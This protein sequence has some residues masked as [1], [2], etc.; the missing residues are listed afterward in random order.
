MFARRDIVA[1]LLLFN[2]FCVLMKNVN[3]ETDGCFCKLKGE[4]DDCGCTV[5]SVD[6]FNNFKIYPRIN[7]L[8]QKDFFK[9]FKVNLKRTCPFWPDDSRCSLRDCHVEQCTEVPANIKGFSEKKRKHEKNKYSEE[10][11]KEEKDEDCD[12]ELGN[13]DKTISV[14]GQKQFKT[15]Q[16]HDDAQNYFCELDDEKSTDSD[17][18]DLLRNP[19]RY[20]GYVGNSPQRIWHSIYEENCFKPTPGYGYHAGLCLEQRVFYRL[21]SGLHTSINIHLCANYLL[22]K[23]AYGVQTW[24]LNVPE[25]M[26]R[27][28]PKLTAG[29]GPQRL[30]NLYFTYLVEL[31]ALMKASLYLEKELYYT[32]SDAVDQDTKIAVKEFLDNVKTF[33]EHFDEGQLF[34]GD[35]KEALK[36][37]TEFRDHFYN[38]T[39]IMDCVGCDKCK[40]WGKL[41]VTG[42]GTALKI[43]FS[44]TEGSMVQP[45]DTKFQLTRPEIVAL[46]NG[47]GRLATSIKELEL[48]RKKIAKINR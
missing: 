15:W 4:I 20:T 32:G 3:C 29:E 38:I 47:F 42:M 40:L 27:F 11:Q 35:T 30:K 13:L 37:K 8:L 18:V 14:E 12:H 41:Q 28:D 44:S 31:R 17:Y 1:V 7:S 23:N 2:V 36:L 19:E 5:E 46:F 34:K 24:G 6:H 21:I 22:G 9:Y 48:F 25:F 26:R 33:N 16:K 43:L 45:N 39:R 10:A